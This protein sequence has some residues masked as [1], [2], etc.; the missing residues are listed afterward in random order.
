MA[1]ERPGVFSLVVE[2]G[3]VPVLS[4]LLAGVDEPCWALLGRLLGW[5]LLRHRDEAVL[6]PGRVSLKGE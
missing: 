5:L 3:V 6:E 1:A 2:L 4:G